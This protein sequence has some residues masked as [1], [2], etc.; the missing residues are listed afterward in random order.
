M[1]LWKLLP[2]G[3]L[4]W[5]DPYVFKIK[6][7]ITIADL[8]ELLLAKTQDF[9]GCK[10]F[11]KLQHGLMDFDDAADDDM[12]QDG[13]IYVKVEPPPGGLLLGILFYGTSLACKRHGR[14]VV[15]GG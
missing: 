14:R 2:A 10:F 6:P 5:D 11:V 9:P 7:Q 8:K 3:T 4:A 12:P 13:N 1:C 15:R